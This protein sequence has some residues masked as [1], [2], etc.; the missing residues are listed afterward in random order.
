MQT[1]SIAVG[2]TRRP[3]VNAVR[4]AV[5]ALDPLIGSGVQFDICPI[6]AP[7]GVG[8]TP[9]SREETMRGA[10]QRAESMVGIARDKN[11]RAGHEP[12]AEY[13]VKFFN[14]RRDPV[15]FADFNLAQRDDFYM[16][17]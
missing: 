12:A 14:P 3:K 5:A 16:T 6:D 8:H 9:L 7:S 11:D 15:S 2:S 1:I 13:A 4:E 10:R 17:I